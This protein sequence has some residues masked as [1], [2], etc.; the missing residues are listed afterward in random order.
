VAGHD[1]AV[2]AAVDALPGALVEL[3]HGPAMT[4]VASRLDVLDARYYE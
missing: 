4:G 3:A 2:D 1:A